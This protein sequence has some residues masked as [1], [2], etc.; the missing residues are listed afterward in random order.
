MTFKSARHSVLQEV[1]CLMVCKDGQNAV[2]CRR[3][4]SDETVRYKSY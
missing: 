4:D 3:H 2:E 1:S